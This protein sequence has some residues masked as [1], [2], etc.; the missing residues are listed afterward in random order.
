MVS[1]RPLAALPVVGVVADGRTYRHLLYLFVSLLLWGVYS[2]ILPL[3]ILFGAVL[4]VVLVGV[5]I[6]IGV[7]IGSRLLASFERWLANR[8]LGTTLVAPDD[9]PSGA[10]GAVESVRGYLTAPSTWRGLGFISLKLWVALLAFVPLFVLASALPLVAAPVRYPYET[11]FGEVN[12]EP[13]IWAIDA[14]PEAALA[15]AVG[16]VGV[17]VG[18]HLTNLIAGGTRLMAVALLGTEVDD[19]PNAETA[20]AGVARETGT[21]ANDG[22]GGRA[23]DTDGERADD[24]EHSGDDGGGDDEHSGGDDGHSGG[25]AD[26]FRF[27]A[28]R[29]DTGDDRA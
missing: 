1:L 29:D 7:V 17:L 4:S 18:L 3:G 26:E 15:A 14:A 28:D 10:T 16:V 13:V 11:E 5:A 2:T 8:L 19:Q 23:G 21:G 20:S 27:G 6:L 22:D 9:V 12:G 25:D 24:D